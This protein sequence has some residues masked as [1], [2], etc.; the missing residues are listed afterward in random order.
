M[1]DIFISYASA[2]RDRVLPL[3]N[4]LEKTGWSVFWDR[5]IPTGKT[6]RQVIGSEVQTCRSVVVVWTENSIA[7]E[8]VHEEAETGKHKRILIPIL[9]D[10]VQPPF[11]F[12]N[13]QAANLAAW[14][15][16]TSTPTFTRLVADIATII[17]PPPAATKKGEE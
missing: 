15:G 1:S 6:W 11:G 4:A 5:T 7:S 9:L 2:D 16:N 3:V 17:G 12:G 14:D 13:V 10:K 8:W